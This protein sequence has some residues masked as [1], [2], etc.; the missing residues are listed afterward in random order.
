MF[1]IGEVAARSGV[2]EGTL[3]MWER[4]HGFPVPERLPSGHRRYSDRQVKLVRRVAD[5]RA[6]GLTLAVAIER[7]LEAER[8]STGSVFAELRRVRPDLAP[9]SLT[10]PL[11]TA[12][13]HAIEDE[14]LARAERPVLFG[15]FQQ[16]R[17]YRQAE[18][19]WRAFARQAELAIVFAD[20]PKARRPR[21]RPVELR[22]APEHPLTREWAV[23][24]D[25]PGHAA[26]LVGWEPPGPRP[27]GVPRTFEAIWSVE[28]D[29]VRQAALVCARLAERLGGDDF[30]GV[31]RRLQ[32]APTP[33][34][35][36]QLRLATALTNRALSSLPNV[37]HGSE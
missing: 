36:D 35:S 29:A 12:L 37:A 26:C 15:A 27:A 22:L 9:R 33:V 17:F 19:R 7:A 31:S 25:A 10:K 4:R 20:F 5:G 30:D 32:A 2:P 1:N 11:M 18:R 8:P 24:C 28:P 16:E 34:L 14:S 13:S 23:I 6:A 3:R 21:G